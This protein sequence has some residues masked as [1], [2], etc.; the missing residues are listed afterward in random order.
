MLTYWVIWL[1]AAAGV[2]ARDWASPDLRR[3]AW[4]GFGVVL[5]LFAGLRHDV[6]GDWGTYVTYV[7]RASEMSFIDGLAI[8]DP[9]YSAVN[10]LGA[11]GFG[12]IYFVNLCCAAIAVAGLM[13][14]C[15]RQANPAL[16][17]AV[18]VPYLI[19]VVFLGYSRQSAAI[20]FGLLAMLAVGERKEWQFLLWTTLAALFHK[21]ALVF[22]VFAPALYAHRFEWRH[23]WRLGLIGIYALGLT[24]LLLLPRLAWF[25][26]S[27]VVISA[28]SI[29][30]PSALP[31]LGSLEE[32]IVV[33]SS[34]VYSRGAQLRLG[35]GLLAAAVIGI[36]VGR[37]LLSGRDA[38]MWAISAVC[39]VVLFI[40]ALFKA[41][42]ADRMGLYFIPT[43]LVAFSM[44]PLLFAGRFQKPAEIVVL[45]GTLGLLAGW[46]L[47]A[48]N[49]F[50][51]LPYDNV[52]FSLLPTGAS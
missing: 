43:Q 44:V 16:A 3:F 47:F 20:G 30:S 8:D 22:F 2:V 12:G 15:S 51:W 1:L 10:W 29:G 35:I 41:T 34:V 18:A 28:G 14:F 6:G 42:L 40:L 38:W 49:A 48:D 7:E 25:W 37:R 24:A 17:L 32:E 36:L 45:L 23:L 4:I 21:S 19:T 11:H 27:Y 13:I 52:L 39:V 9:G 5:V 46:L 26:N 33:D 50:A 31:S